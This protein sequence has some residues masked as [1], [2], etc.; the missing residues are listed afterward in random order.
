MDHNNEIDYSILEKMKS[1]NLWG[2]IGSS[3]YKGGDGNLLSAIIAME[4][5]ARG[6]AS[7]AI[8]ID[9]HWLCLKGIERFGNSHQKQKYLYDLCSGEKIGAFAWTEPEAGSDAANISTSALRKGDNYILN[10]SKCFCTNG[11]LAGIYLIGAVTDPNTSPKQLSVF[12]VDANTPG[13]QVGRKED[14]MGL[15]GSHTTELVLKEL[16]I[17]RQQRLGNKG[18]GFNIFTSLLNDGRLAVA[19]LCLGIAKAALNASVV[20]ASKRFA[21]GKPIIS[22]QAIQFMIAEMDTEINAA[23]LLAYQ[24]A[25]KS[26][27]CLNFGKESAQAKYFASDMAMRVCKNA[28]QIHGGIGYTKEYNVERYFRNAKFAEIGEGTTE[29]LKSLVAKSIMKE[30]IH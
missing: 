15:R 8:T 11:G 18:A 29:V 4:E 19:G 10:G 9:A 26:T 28:I 14:K 3:K 16:K 25:F 1:I 23:R 13:L 21:F 30:I 22:K 20:Y 2:L 5:L 17:P 27:Q 24:A 6:S 7:I 12:I